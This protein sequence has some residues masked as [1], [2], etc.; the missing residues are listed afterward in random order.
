MQHK[1]LEVDIIFS[2]DTFY[3]QCIYRFPHSFWSSSWIHPNPFSFT[4]LVTM[5]IRTFNTTLL[6]H[7]LGGTHFIFSP[8]HPLFFRVRTPANLLEKRLFILLAK[9]PSF[10]VLTF[11]SQPYPFFKVTNSFWGLVIKPYADV[12]LCGC[13]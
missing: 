2:K 13:V 7:F 3:C 4:L 10:C 6:L 11:S 8:I 9:K 1:T 5:L 12:S